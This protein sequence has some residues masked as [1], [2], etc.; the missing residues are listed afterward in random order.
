MTC[1]VLPVLTPLTARAGQM[2][3]HLRHIALRER[4]HRLRGKIANGVR[5]Y[6]IRMFR[7]PF[8][9][10]LKCGGV[11]ECLGNDD[12]GR[13][14]ALLECNRVVHTAQRT[15][16]SASHRHHGHVHVARHRVNECRNRG[17]GV[18]FLAAQT[19]PGDPIMLA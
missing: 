3:G 4:P 9:A 8:G 18:V 14:A 19:D 10:K 2:L 12:C 6:D 13:D 5:Q 15:R 7:H 16:A 1:C 11:G 17:F